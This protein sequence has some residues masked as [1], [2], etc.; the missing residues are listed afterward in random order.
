M[1]ECDSEI[2]VDDG[3]L[4][5]LVVNLEMTIGESEPV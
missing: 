3:A 5:C 1:I 2:V 4:R